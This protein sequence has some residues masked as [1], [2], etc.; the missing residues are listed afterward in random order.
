MT[1][2]MRFPNA[3]GTAALGICESLILALTETKVLSEQDARDLL[4]DVAAAHQQCAFV[5]PDDAE[6][7][8]AVIAT[9]Q[10]ILAGKNGVRR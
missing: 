10:R 2:A 6:L 8:H 1:E 9:V 3:D 4:A 5:A 7:H